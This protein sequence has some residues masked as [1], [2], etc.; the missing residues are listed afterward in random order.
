MG[1]IPELLKKPLM[2]SFLAP[3][4]GRDHMQVNST[5]ESKRDDPK[6]TVSGQIWQILSQ[7]QIDTPYGLC[8]LLWELTD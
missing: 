3:F 5:N 8:A 7:C 1:D 4:R 2:W 6:T